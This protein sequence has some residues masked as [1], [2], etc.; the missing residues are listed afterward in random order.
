MRLRSTILVLRRLVVVWFTGVL[1][2]DGRQGLLVGGGL[3]LSDGARVA[4]L[5]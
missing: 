4:M 3:E 1:V 2:N 5:G